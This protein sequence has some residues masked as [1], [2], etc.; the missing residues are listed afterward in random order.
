MTQWVKTIR[1][2]KDCS[3]KERAYNFGAGP[4]MLPEV[5]LKQAQHDLLNWQDQGM[6]ILEIGHRTADFRALLDQAEATLR[7][8][9][10]IPAYYQVLFLAGPA[11]MLFSMI[12]MNLLSAQQQG[13]YLVT[14]IWS[15]MAYQEA[16]HVR[17]A[18]CVASS[19]A[20]G[21][22][23][24]PARDSW[25][26]TSD[27]VVK[28]ASPNPLAYLYYTPN[29]TVNGLYCPTPELPEDLPL[30]A[31]MTSCLLAEPIQVSQYDLIF[32]GA[33]KNIANA[34]LTVVIVSDRLLA[35]I[36]QDHLPTIFDL[37]THVA[38]RSLYTTPPTFNCYLANKM[39]SWIEEQGGVAALHAI[40][41][42]KAQKLYDY[43]D[44]SSFYHCL[45]EAPYRSFLNVCFKLADPSQEDFFI[46]QAKKRH[47][48]ALRG[49]RAVGGLRASLYNAMPMEGVDCLIEFMRDFAK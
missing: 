40:N 26:L 23:T 30:I 21:F 31:D 48:L 29:E 38:H 9:L 37:R 32:A 46:E 7:R 4:A 44:A 8:L 11:R 22:T 3:H 18:T 39:F 15:L 35:S 12:P 16:Q 25:R 41:Q 6:S 17:A 47:L 1:M 33:Q 28:N 2:S 43:I 45:V 49:H 20:T 27:N 34:G 19:E 36:Q 5:L 24:V 13:G 42:A 10:T 14:G